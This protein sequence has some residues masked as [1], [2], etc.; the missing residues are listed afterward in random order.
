MKFEES[1]GGIVFKKEDSQ[2]YILITQH[3]QHHGWIFPKGL[4]EPPENPK[5]TAVREVSEEGGVVAKIVQELPPTEYFYQ[6]GGDKIKKKVTY[7]LMEYVSGD[8]G[9]HD[10]EMEDAKWVSVEKVEE[11]LT[12]NSD[13]E[14]FQ[15]AKKILKK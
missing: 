10:W 11:L 14:V 8:P 1:A 12:Y 9:D 7:F 13:K 4:I 2:I 5:T 3:S 6:H 15:K